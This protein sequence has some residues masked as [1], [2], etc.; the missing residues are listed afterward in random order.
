MDNGIKSEWVIGTYTG[1][2]A[3]S[4]KAH[5]DAGMGYFI[6]SESGRG[7][8]YEVEAAF[9]R[10]TDSPLPEHLVKANFGQAQKL[11]RLRNERLGENK[12]Q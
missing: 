6:R 1:D 9:L 7:T 11:D 2:R 8:A 3:K 12:R 4:V 10:A 5:A